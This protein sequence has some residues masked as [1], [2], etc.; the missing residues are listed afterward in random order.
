MLTPLKKQTNKQTISKKTSEIY[1][2]Q[3]KTNGE[4]FL[5]PDCIFPAPLLLPLYEKCLYREKSLRQML[6]S[7]EKHKESARLT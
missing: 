7:R 3:T 1:E 2:N 5:V 4:E 6:P